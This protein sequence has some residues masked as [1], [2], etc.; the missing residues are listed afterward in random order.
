MSEAE[1]YKGGCHCG[2]IRYQVS[3]PTVM[4]EYCHCDDCR[5]SMGSAVSALAG[6]RKE[7]FEIIKGTPTYHD[8]TSVVTRSFCGTCGSPLFYENRDYPDDLYIALGSFDQP[9]LLPP[10]R[11]VWTSER[12]DWYQINDDLPQHKQFSGTGSAEAVAP[13]GNPT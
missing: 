9:E 12:I 3:G 4:V 13:D 10:D 7:A 6:F 1:L 5:K 11:H 8:P 2:A